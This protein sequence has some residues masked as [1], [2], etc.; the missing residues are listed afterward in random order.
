MCS[1]LALLLAVAALS[2]HSMTASAAEED[3]PDYARPG[4]YIGVGVSGASYTEIANFVED[5][6]RGVGVPVNVDTDTG[7]GFDLYGGYRAHPNIA[8]EA[9]FEMIPATDLKL[10][11]FGRVAE[12][13]TWTLTSNFKV[14]PITGK[15]QPFLL[16]GIGL[17]HGKL[18]DTLG[19]GISE[20]DIDF[21]AR[22]GGGADFYITEHLAL[23][24]KVSYVLATGVDDVL[25]YVSFGGGAAYRF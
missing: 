20:S 1:R 12:I 23:T 19:Q 6:L 10:S 8:V 21:A 2:V 15:A 3:A 11:G 7:V 4:F 24:A 14:F 9:E 13:E 5:E 25:D 18:E 22:F 17:L 16:V